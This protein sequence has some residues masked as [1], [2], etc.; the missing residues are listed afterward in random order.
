M[1]AQ[2]GKDLLLKIDMT[3]EGEFATVAGLRSRSSR[4]IRRRS[5]SRIRNRRGSGAS[6]WLAPVSN[7]PASTAPAFSRMQTP[8]KPCAR[9]SSAALSARGR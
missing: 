3:G 9:C 7:R 5:T 8:T 6:C 1:A 4:S 2:K